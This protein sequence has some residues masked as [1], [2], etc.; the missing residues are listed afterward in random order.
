MGL[1]PIET[2]SFFEVREKDTVD[3]GIKLQIIYL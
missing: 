2:A 1:A 3:S